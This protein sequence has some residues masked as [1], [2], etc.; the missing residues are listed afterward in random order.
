MVEIDRKDTEPKPRSIR[1]GILGTIGAGKSTLASMLGERWGVAPVTE[2]FGENPYLKLFY[3]NPAA[4]SFLSQVWFLE[5]KV[6]QLSSINTETAQIVDPALEMDSIYAMA[7]HRSGWMTDTEWALYKQL[8]RTLLSKNEKSP[9]SSDFYIIVKA[10]PEVIQR[11]I[12]SRGREFERRIDAGYTTLLAECIDEWRQTVGNAPTIDVDLGYYDL[13]EN[14]ND[15]REQVL[16]RIEGT[17]GLFLSRDPR[18]IAGE[19]IIGP[20]FPLRASGVD[21]S[22]ALSAEER[23]L[24][25]R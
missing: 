23:M 7:H 5:K 3:E 14:R 9:I 6:K 19:R 17:L 15:G 2:I 13:V 16:G 20:S 12:A 8:F 11:R 24:R 10:S 21:I 22:P 4:Y 18:S 1:V 25:R